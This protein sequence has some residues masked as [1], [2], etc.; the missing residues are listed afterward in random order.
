[1]S[2][3]AD[4]G[5]GIRQEDIPQLFSDYS[6]VDTRSNRSIEGTGL[7]LSITRR[8][9]ELMDGSVSV[10]SE[11]AKGSVFT[12]R[13]KQKALG[14]ETLGRELAEKLA[15]FNYSFEK[16]TRN[17][18]L[19]RAWLPYASVLV[20]DD[21]P[22]NLDVAKGLL[23]PYGMTIDCVGSG[24]A[25]IE[26]VRRE[27]PRYSAI[28]MDHMMPGM[29]GMETLR[30]IRQEI[31]TEYAQTVPVIALTADAI[32]GN[33]RLFLERG[34]QA[35]LTKPI[36]IMRLDA[37]VSRW[38]RDRKRE[39]ELKQSGENLA[40]PEALQ[41]DP[42]EKSGP[43]FAAARKIKGL[44]VSRGIEQ[45]GGRIELWLTVLRSYVNHLPEQL[46]ILRAVTDE[47]LVA[48]AIAV[49]GIKGASRGIGA[50]PLGLK[51]ED[52]EKA[53][54]RNNLAFVLSEN[55]NFIAQT[56]NLAKEL[57]ALLEESDETDKQSKSLRDAPEGELLDRIAE[58]CEA[59]DMEGLD[60]AIAA[61]EQ[62][63]YTSGQELVQWLRAQSGRSGFEAILDRLA[64][65]RK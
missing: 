2:R 20:V 10:E 12:V 58:A 64:K 53:A 41:E 28:F 44:D 8:F 34:F 43:L 29:D 54:R 3:V 25:A 38:V 51:A 14:N 39:E 17:Q 6:Q 63:R 24:K 65:E 19:V 42:E 52:L 56:E 7:G 50:Y 22:V 32:V 9:A 11:Y 61:L 27:N 23:S 1:V 30:I 5:I 31:G 55:G 35:F 36:D 4:T 33:E 49:H 48:Y 47:T 21:V 57:R 16:R 40:P 45:A 60:R 13:V 62:Y 37:V 18:K 26:R 15:H 59:Y 46:D